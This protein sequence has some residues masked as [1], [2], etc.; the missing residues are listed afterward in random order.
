[1]DNKRLAKEAKT[2]RPESKKGN[3]MTEERMEWG[4]KPEKTSCITLY[5]VARSK[6]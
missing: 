3:G 6:F 1:M 2:C 4:L 5:C